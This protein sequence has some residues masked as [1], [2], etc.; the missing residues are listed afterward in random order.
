MARKQVKSTSSSRRDIPAIASVRLDRRV[1]ESFRR[2]VKHAYPNEFME[3]IFGQVTEDGEALV[4]MFYPFEHT[5]DRNNC[6]FD[7]AE[8]RHLEET[9]Q[10]LRLHM[11]GTAHSHP[12]YHYCCHPSETDHTTGHEFGEL[13][14]A[15]MH[16]YKKNGVMNTRVSWNV[17]R[18]PVKLKFA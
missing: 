6:H 5:G 11:L 16:V 9:A 3:A 18:K 17:P 10:E 15:V 2:R 4:H 7:S 13:L 8:Y 14:M 1:L 12:G